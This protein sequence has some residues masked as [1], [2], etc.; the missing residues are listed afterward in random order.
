MDYTAEPSPPGSIAPCGVVRCRSL[1]AAPAPP[2]D[3]QFQRVEPLDVP[4]DG[5]ERV[6]LRD[7]CLVFRRSLRFVRLDGHEATAYERLKL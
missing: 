4:Q 5:A 2:R 1:T 6:G 3:D 7:A